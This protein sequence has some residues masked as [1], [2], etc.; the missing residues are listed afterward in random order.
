MEKE[1]QGSALLLLRYVLLEAQERLSLVGVLGVGAPA[2]L[3]LPSLPLGRRSLGTAASG[4]GD[5]W[6]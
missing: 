5:S 4:Y 1:E 3:S 6:G 2:R